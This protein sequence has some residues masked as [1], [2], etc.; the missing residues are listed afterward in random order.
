MLVRGVFVQCYTK[1][2][3]LIFNY[4]GKD[5]P[6]AAL[7][8]SRETTASG[9]PYQLLQATTESQHKPSRV[10][11]NQCQRIPSIVVLSLW[12]VRSGGGSI[13]QRREIP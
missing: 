11:P 4:G 2:A 9:T 3:K 5:P 1:R 10:R 8:I 13:V 12:R 6:A 7:T